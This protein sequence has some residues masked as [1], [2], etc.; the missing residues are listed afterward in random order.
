VSFDIDENGILNVTA[1]DKSTNKNAKITITNNKGRL[2]KEE[3][4]RLVKE[5][6]KFK[7]ED[8]VI[9]KRIESKNTLESYTFSI[10]N[11][12]KDEKLKDKIKADEREKV[13]KLIEET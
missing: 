2:T 11:S 5:A 10:R 6:E 12:L 1:T 8:E 4:E 3:I 13:E 9:K 7:G